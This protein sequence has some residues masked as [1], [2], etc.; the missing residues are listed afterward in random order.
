MNF[1]KNL[2]SDTQWK[3][4]LEQSKHEPVLVFKHSTRCS[5]SVM[6]LDRINRSWDPALEPSISAW[7]LD[8]LNYREISNQIATDTGVEHQSPQMLLIRDGQCQLSETHQAIR[9]DD[10]LRKAGIKN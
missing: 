3:E 9:L 2:E 7:Y 6:A 5:I 4:I 8:L 1:W 10:F